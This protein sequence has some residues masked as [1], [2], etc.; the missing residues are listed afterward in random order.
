MHWIKEELMS[1]YWYKNLKNKHMHKK[2][3]FSLLSGWKRYIG[4]YHSGHLTEEGTF[5]LDSSGNKQLK[6]CC[7]TGYGHSLNKEFRAC[8]SIHSHQQTQAADTG[9]RTLFMSFT[10]QIRDYMIN[11]IFLS[12][13]NKTKQ[14]NRN[15]RVNPE[16]NAYKSSLRGLQN[17]SVFSTLI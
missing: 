17:Q 3:A 5:Y 12:K 6:L 9:S 10:G 14:T 13:Q 4:K 2:T 7:R 15:T 16:N 11:V 8:T 1:P